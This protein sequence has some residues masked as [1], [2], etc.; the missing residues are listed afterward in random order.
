[1][2]TFDTIINRRAVLAPA[3]QTV[4]SGVD[5]VGGRCSRARIGASSPYFNRLRDVRSGIDPARS[6]W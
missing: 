3:P 5:G 2:N 1:M 4:M 6:G